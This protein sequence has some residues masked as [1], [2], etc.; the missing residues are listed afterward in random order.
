MQILQTHL[1]EEDRTAFKALN[2]WNEP[3][4]EEKC[5][6]TP[7]TRNPPK[8][9]RVDNNSPVY[10]KVL[11]QYFEKEGKYIHPDNYSIGDWVTLWQKDA[12]GRKLIVISADIA[13]YYDKRKVWYSY[14]FVVIFNP[15][16]SY[17]LDTMAPLGDVST[18]SQ[19]VKQVKIIGNWNQPLA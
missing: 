12:Y 8:G 5:D 19:T 1:T 3:L 10:E 7:I 4:Q 18:F 11:L 9:G 17:N 15:D 14:T 13:D 2:D 16:G 6:S